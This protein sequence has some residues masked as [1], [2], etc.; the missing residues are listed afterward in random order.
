[1]IRAEHVPKHGNTALMRSFKHVTPPLRLY[2]GA[3]SLQHLASDLERLNSRRA[4]IFCGATLA[5]S[6]VL[7]LVRSAL[8]GR[9][10]GVFAGVRTHSPHPS[11]DIGA[12]ELKRLEADAVIA[13]GGGSAV[14]T[15]RAA[16][17]YL[18]EG[19]DLTQLSTSRDAAGN[20][21]S[22]KLNAPK[23][24][25]LIVPT[26][27]NTATVKAGNAVFDPVHARR[28][29]LFDPKTRAQSVYI[30]PALMMSAPRKLAV[31]A[32][33]DTLALAIEGLT[34][35]QGDPISDGLLIHSLRLLI[36]SLSHPRLEEDADVRC[37][38]MLAA[39]LGG[40]GTDYTGAGIAT[41]LGHAIGANHGIDNGVAKAI[42][43]PYTIRFNAEASPSGIEKLGIAFGSSPAASS[44]VNAVVDSF[45]GLLER[46]GGV[47]R[48]LRELSIPHNALATVARRAMEDWFVSTN[49]RPVHDS[50]E[51]QSILEDAW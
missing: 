12:Q 32:S 34:S 3:D 6:S 36:A 11:V 41:V 39:V 13:V 5:R 17:I 16:S 51:L 10:A 46:I 31:S 23:L 42:V 43:L 26:T 19:N 28:F 33:F 7:E 18:A 49:P 15:A 2:C 4:V 48:R 27:P 37:D 45:A 14:V 22:P 50:S 25:Q 35:H 29:A 8:G 44:A 30:H 21:H 38:L 24:P 1:M 9:C 40:Q 47:P 20:L